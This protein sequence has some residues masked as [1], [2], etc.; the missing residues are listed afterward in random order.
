MW[1]HWPALLHRQTEFDNIWRLFRNNHSVWK[2]DYLPGYFCLSIGAA[3][4]YYTG[5]FGQILEITI[6]IYRLFENAA[7]P[8]GL[9]QLAECSFFLSFLLSTLFL[10][11]AL[12]L[13]PVNITKIIWVNKNLI[14]TSLLESSLFRTYF[15]F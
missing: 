15:S 11:M 6:T 12:L 10:W 14:C 13:D 2:R 8:L 1:R 3:K 4:I 7:L 9:L 5:Y